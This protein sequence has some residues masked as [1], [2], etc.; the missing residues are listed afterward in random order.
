MMINSNKFTK[1]I[2][3]KFL[4]LAIAVVLWFMVINTENPLETRSYTA[5]I[6]IQNEESLFE[7]GYVV[8]NED[9]ISS[10]R[11]TVRLRGQRLALDTLSQSNTKVQAV[12]DLKNVIYSYSGEPVSV[13]VSIVIPSVVN[14]SFEILS[15]S[16][17]SVTVDIQPYI[18]KDFQVNPVVNY[19]DESAMELVS[20]AASPNTITV[21]GAKSI[22]N[23][24]AEVRA[25]ITP[26]T[27]ENDM[28]L[29]A[30][31]LAYDSEGNVVENVTFSSSELSVKISMDDMKTV[32]LV[33][34]TDGSAAE[35]Y[36][37]TGLYL[38]P[39]TIDVAGSQEAL[40]GISVIRLPDID[41]SG[42]DSNLI[43]DFNISDYLPDGA[44]V[45]GG[46]DTVTATV[47]VEQDETR[48]VVIPAESITDNGTVPEGLTAEIESGDLEITVSGPPSEMEFV[49]SEIKAYV[50]LSGY[51]AGVYEDV[52]VVIELPDGISLVSEPAAVTVVL[53]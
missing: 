8:V 29:T 38:S 17:Q 4:S 25:E 49:S 16:V 48:T 36:Q 12:V 13:P 51:E 20:A 39:E 41:I 3:W 10:T 6:Q 42:I 34:D 23:S 33:V 24:I 27:L 44:R 52:P 30:A 43:Q 53:S 26:E 46:N 2:G 50:D 32:R 11:I 31:P 45:V 14:N 47:T 5:S 37:V 1:N 35:G 9:E 22:V 21:Y 28:V 18:N 7:R 40:S 19:D 15:K